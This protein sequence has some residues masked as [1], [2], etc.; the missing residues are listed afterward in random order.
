M[1]DKNSNKANSL[2]IDEI[3]VLANSLRIFPDFRFILLCEKTRNYVP[4]SPY[5]GCLQYQ[6]HKDKE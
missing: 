2:Y 6:Q 4:L 5:E 3:L 1:S